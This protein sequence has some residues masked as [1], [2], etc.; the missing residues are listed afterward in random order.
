MKWFFSV[1]TV[2]LGVYKAKSIRSLSLQ[3]T[4]FV[5]KR[6]GFQINFWAVKELV[7]SNQ[8]TD[9]TA[10]SEPN[11]RIKHDYIDNGA[12]ININMRAQLFST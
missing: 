7:I 1:T 12:V 11:T 9:K 4:L 2:W 5:T 8:I 6:N 10:A 3:Y